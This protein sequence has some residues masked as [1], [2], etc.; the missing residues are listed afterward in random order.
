MQVLGTPKQHFPVF[1]GSTCED[2][3]MYR[4]AVR[5]ALTQMEHIVRG[6]EY[7]GSKPGSPKE[8][9]LKAV[10]SCRV[11]IGIFAMRYGSV[12]PEKGK[13][14]THLEYDEAQRLRLPTLIYLI[15]EANQPV[16]PM[17]VDTGE[18][19][20]K[21]RALKDEL[22]SRFVVSFFTTPEDLA[23]R[24]AQDLP[25]LL[26]TL[27]PEVHTER[28]RAGTDAVP[29]L[30]RLPMGE[31]RSS[32]ALTINWKQLGCPTEPGNVKVQGV[33]IVQVTQEDIK[34][35]AQ[36]G[37]NCRVELIDVSATK[38]PM[39]VYAIGKFIP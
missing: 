6:M 29:F 38:D 33:G 17:H 2:L 4:A 16:L 7:F 5:D 13:S 37:E 21:L 9:C 26:E 34:T 10:A 22:K 15:D 31:H 18:K 11:Y 36:L 24:I 28:I 14:M 23:R 25:C 12:D 19:A 30:Q 1:V 35:A 39:P 8:E 3:K 32:E 27:A 20:E